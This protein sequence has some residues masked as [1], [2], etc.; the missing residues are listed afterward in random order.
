ME[1]A[2]GPGKALSVPEPDPLSIN[3]FTFDRARRLLDDIA[4]ASFDRSELSEKLDNFLPADVFERAAT[5]VGEFG[6][7]L[8]M[9]AFAEW[10]TAEGVATYFRVQY[11]GETLTW[12]VGLDP[13]DRI[14]A[15]SLRRNPRNKI[16]NVSWQNIGYDF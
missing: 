15:L 11:S 3:E 10:R 1:N 2:S 12:A 4:N 13:D 8:S 14:T 16:F 7:P 5:L 9:F 6:P